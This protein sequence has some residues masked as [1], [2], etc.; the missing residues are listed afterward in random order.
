MPPSTA[1]QVETLRLTVCTVYSVT[2]EFAT[3]A[4]P[5]SI[6]SR[7]PGPSS[8]WTVVDDRVDVVGDRRRL[9]LG[10]V[11]DAEP[12][13]EVVDVEVAERRE[14]RDRVRG[15]ARARA[16][17]SRCGSAARRAAD[18]D[19]SRAARSR[20]RPRSSPKPNFES[21][22]PVEIAAWVSPETSGVT[23]ISTSWRD[24]PARAATRSSRSRSSNES[25][26]MWPTPAR[27]RLAQLRLGLGVAVQVDP[28]RIEAAAQRERQLAA[29]GHIARE[30]LRGEQPVD[31]RARETPSRRTA[32]RCRRWRARSPSTKARARARRSSSATT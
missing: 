26:T 18:A 30:P 15:T 24:A 2:V 8:A 16:A 28:R 7:L 19:A 22:W 29:G 4:R 6:S 14:R 3:S 9:L 10:G 27:Q 23:R 31:G 12:A 5:G 1:T 25:S 13:A 32:R 21:A 11:R 20:P 17:A